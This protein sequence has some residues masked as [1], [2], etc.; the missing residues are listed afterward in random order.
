MLCLKIEFPDKIFLLR[1]NHES[2]DVNRAFGFY[3]ECKRKISLKIYKRFC[4]LFNILPIT[5]LIGEKI[6]CMHGG[7]S[8]ELTNINQLK[9]IKRPTEIPEKGL[10]CDLVWS[11]PDS[12]LK[13]WE[14]NEVQGNYKSF[15][16]E[17]HYILQSRI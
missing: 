12:N 9:I 16:R 17:V 11:D 6:L 5:A 3:D 2:A 4:N 10:L 14:I 15:R 1:G 7:L 13:G 8:K